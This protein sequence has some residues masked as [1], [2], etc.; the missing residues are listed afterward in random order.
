MSLLALL[1]AATAPQQ[2]YFVDRAADYGVDFQHVDG[3]G[4]YAMGGG[5]AW[6]DFDNDGDDDLFTASSDGA[7]RLYRNDGGA[8]F[9]DVTAASGLV[10]PQVNGAIMVIAGDYDGDGWTDLYIGGEGPNRLMQNQGDGTFIDRAA[11]EGVDSLAWTASASWVDFDLDGDL[12]LYLGNY[13][14][15]LSFPYHYGRANEYFENQ[16]DGASPR[17]VERAQE[18]GISDEAIFGPTVPGF[19]YISPEGEATA[20][21]TLSVCTHDYDEDGDQDL[22]IGND[23]GEWVT[24]NKLFRND[25]DLGNGLAFTDVSTETGFDADPHYNMGIAGADY[26]LDGDFDF[27]ESNLGDNH[28]LRNDDGYFNNAVYAAGVES[29]VSDDPSL[30]LTSWGFV[31]SDFD[32]DL[33]ED[34]YV[35]NGLIPAA[36]F[37]ANDPRSKNDLYLNRA[38]GTFEQ[39]APGQSGAADDAVGRGLAPADVDRD[40]LVDLFVMNNGGPSVALP[41]DVAR[42]FMADPAQLNPDGTRSAVQLRLQATKSHWQAFGARLSAEVGDVTL[43][44]QLLC[45]PVYV[46]SASR[47]VHFGIGE[48]NEVDRLRIQWPSGTL[49]ELVGVPAGTQATIVEPTVMLRDI[50]PSELVQG[51]G[52]P[53]QFSAVLL[54]SSDAPVS[55]TVLMDLRLGE[56][57]P[58]IFSATSLPFDTPPQSPTVFEF[59]IGVTTDVI[60]VLRT[61]TNEVEVR[62]YAIA[63][64]AIDSKSQ[65]ETLP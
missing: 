51:S 61:L 2:P 19:P 11:F 25:I 64:G 49:Q 42:L 63:D 34:L 10:T 5:A 57:G 45:D 50:L 41:G 3:I 12:D 8:P 31:W 59:Q 54:N 24:G 53:A 23:F 44:R 38:D 62:F 20:G 26:D 32:L 1:L 47:E 35:V 29:G 40:G 39:V 43:K 52:F 58:S 17:F 14:D 56:G 6:L 15:S 37:I 16:G 46:S 55:T 18:L 28:L 9:S 7:H 60:R 22:M 4:T 21:C 27:Y 33:D 36:P 30:L 13:V 48:A 65:V